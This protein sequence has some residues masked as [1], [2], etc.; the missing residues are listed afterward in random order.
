M[1]VVTTTI[2]LV[3]ILFVLSLSD[4]VMLVVRPAVAM[5]GEILEKC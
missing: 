3:V 1:A 5:Q 4:V 2:L